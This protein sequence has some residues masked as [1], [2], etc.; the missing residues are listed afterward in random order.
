MVGMF[1]STQVVYHALMGAYGEAGRWEESVASL[2]EMKRTFPVQ[3]LGPT[4]VCPPGLS[5]LL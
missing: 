2:Q 1:L 4:H 5:P 3:S